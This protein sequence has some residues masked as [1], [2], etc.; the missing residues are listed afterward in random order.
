M[1][2]GVTVW[3]L[4]RASGGAQY[5]VQI[6]PVGGTCEW[7]AILECTA[8][9][10]LRAAVGIWLAGTILYSVLHVFHMTLALRNL[11]HHLYEEQRVRHVLVRIEV[12]VAL[13][14]HGVVHLRA[15][16]TDACA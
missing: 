10:P 12:R 5:A 8:G 11:K 9:S 6:T 14:V 2:A 3:L 16:G 4:L 7:G 15:V 13:V 1:S